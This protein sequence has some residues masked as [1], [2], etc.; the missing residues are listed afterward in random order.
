MGEN[1]KRIVTARVYRCNPM[2]GQ[3]ARYDTYQIE[4]GHPMTVLMVLRHIFRNLD[5]TLAF[6]DFECYRGVCLS[7]TM[8]V[9]GERARACS[10]IVKPGEEITVEPLPGYSLIKDLVVSFD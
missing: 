4:S 3:P 6:R 2:D 8:V 1:E 10:T 7:C 5:P 9:K